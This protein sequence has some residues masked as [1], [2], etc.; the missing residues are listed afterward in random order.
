MCFLTKTGKMRE[1]MNKIAPYMALAALTVFFCLLFICGSGVFGSKV[2]WISQ[3]SVLPEYFRQQFYETGELFPEFAPHIGGGQNIYYFSYYGLYSPVIL[4]S[5]LLPFVKMSDYIMFATAACLAASGMIL[6][7]WLTSR[8]FSQRIAF[9]VA[10]MFLLAGPMIYHSY[11]QIMFVNYMPFLCMGLLGVDRQA[12]DGRSVLVTLSVFL[13]IMT[14][15]YFSIG[16]MLVLTIYGIHRY[17][18][19]YGRWTDALKNISRLLASMV[20]AVLMSGVL[21]VPTAMALMDGERGVGQRSAGALLKLFLP[22]IDMDRFFFSPYGMGLSALATVA[23]V[24]MLF[25]KKM[26]DRVLAGFCIIVL[27]VP[28]FAYALN[29]GLYIRDKVMIPFVPLLSY[30]T[31]CFL[32]AAESGEGFFLPHP[33]RRNALI[34]LLPCIALLAA[35]GYIV[36][37]QAKRTV[38]REFYAEVTDPAIDER[39]AKI[40][41]AEEGFYRTEQLGNTEENAANL[42]RVHSE[43]QYL[44][45]VYSSSY[46]AE[47]QRFR[48]ETFQLEQPYR[49]V[50]M[51]SVSQNPVWQRFM[52][53]KYVLSGDDVY[54]NENA[55]PIAYATD[56]TMS[57]KEYRKLTFPYNQLALLH[58]AV[59]KQEGTHTVSAHEVMES[60]VADSVDL[61]MP[62]EIHA[63]KEQTMQLVIPKRENMG[64]GSSSGRSGEGQTVLF[65]QFTVENQ[66]PSRD[67]AVWAEGIRNKLTAE[68]HFYYNNNT[69][70]TYAFALEDGQTQ[71]QMRFGKGN[72]RIGNVKCYIAELPEKQKGQGTE[73]LYQ[74]EFRVNSEHTKGNVI[75]GTI[76]V[77]KAGY[78]ITTIP[79]DEN[80][81]VRINGKTAPTEKVN[82]AFLGFR[83]NEGARQKIEIIYHA[84]GLRLGKWMSVVGILLLLC[85]WRKRKIMRLPPTYS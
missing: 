39:I 26:Q 48:T 31:A 18:E 20:T 58:Y 32:R 47:Y 60:L 70:F 16:G 65:L 79:Y 55:S 41:E 52:G 12:A 68:N 51:Q 80:F 6:Y 73:S 37:H 71:I 43:R 2:D 82:T 40:T 84:P 11:N 69:A 67:V 14:S 74:S 23:L 9:G 17:L 57:E 85:R 63:E 25:F 66:N 44:S 8:G 45:S 76:D 29:G 56:R 38:S 54:V 75:A 19:I 42:N 4:L 28:I 72:Y 15:F 46:N 53:V 62:K 10:V 36:N 59:V 64:N 34:F 35:S 50:L 5:Y 1:K 78:F 61:H 81:E 3:H 77:K 13:M 30:I 7:G 49:N 83:V 33:K 21:L 27:T 22:Q 24:S